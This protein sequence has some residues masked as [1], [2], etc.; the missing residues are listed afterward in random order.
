MISSRRRFLGQLSLIAGAT[1]LN[2]PF[3]AVALAKHVRVNPS[4]ENMVD[5]YHTCDLNGNL[6]ATCKNMGGLNHVKAELAG[7]NA[8][9][10]LLDCGSFLNKKQTYQQQK[11]V[12]STM[13]AIGYQASTLGS[14]ELDIAPDKLASLAGQ[15]QFTLI[16][17]NY[18]LDY[19]LKQFVKPYII[20]HTGKLKVGITGVG[21][22]NDAVLYNDAAKCANK[23]A[24]LL[25]N[26][27]KCDTVI[28]LSHLGHDN[29]HEL[30]LKSE[31]IDLII[32]GGNEAI[33]G[34]QL[35]LQNKA[36]R[37]VFL[38]QAGHSGL[39]IGKI[40]FAF[41]ADKQQASVASRYF[42][43]GK[44]DKQSH[45]AAFHTICQHERESALVA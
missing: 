33:I 12:I 23:T 36:G 4:A 5:V 43:P 34:S 40:E 11:E 35:L 31:N 1:T 20:V 41:D 42:V 32:G 29:N 21:R 39:T 13:N 45:A 30:A 8:A 44:P 3:T 2:K 37:E 38:C 24:A 7:S 22:R 16:N 28:C 26:E 27:E 14:H 10:L 6:G 15:A 25:K 17:C 9:G 18:D 19:T